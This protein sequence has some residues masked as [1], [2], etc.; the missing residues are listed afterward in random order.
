MITRIVVLALLG[1]TTSTPADA[2]YLYWRDRSVTYVPDELILIAALLGAAAL[3]WFVVEESS[4]T[5]SNVDQLSL[6]LPHELREPQSIEYYDELTDRTRAVMRKLDADTE[7][8]ESYIKAARAR[9][10]LQDIDEPADV[11]GPSRHIARRR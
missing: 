8:A 1:L 9:A 4:S 7:L 10:E 2:V 3:L 5:S 11:F 6:D